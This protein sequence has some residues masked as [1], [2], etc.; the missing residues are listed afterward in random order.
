MSKQKADKAAPA[1][2]DE[3]ERRQRFFKNYAKAAKPLGVK[4]C[5]VLLDQLQQSKEDGGDPSQIVLVDQP[6]GPNGTRALCAAVCGLGLSS[7]SPSPYSDLRT[8]V[9][10]NCE[11]GS[12]GAWSVAE[13]LRVS[14]VDGPHCVPLER[15]EISQNA[16]G[17]AGCRYIGEALVT[18]CNA[19]LHN[20][21]LDQDVSIGDAGVEALVKGLGSNSVLKVLSLA[22]CGVGLA[23]ATSLTKLL[24]SPFSKLEVLNLNGNPLGS[25]GLYVLADVLVWRISDGSAAPRGHAEANGNRTL[26]SL[27]LSDCG[28][29]EGNALDDEGV[30]GD[31]GDGGGEGAA[32]GGG[33]AAPASVAIAA[34]GLPSQSLTEDA[35]RAF[36]DMIASNPILTHVDFNFNLINDRQASHLA[37]AF[38]GNRTLEEFN[39][40]IGIPRPLF[41]KMSRVSPRAGGK[42]GKKGKRGKGGK[43][44]RKEDASR[45]ASVAH[46]SLAGPASTV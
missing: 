39:L 7:M 25:A 1:N 24:S 2:A 10:R 21:V 22:I 38:T 16:I 3:E 29:G 31:G 26:Q 42:K 9:L 19:Y 18:G 20:L 32:V 43:S 33:A 34:G 37:T 11:C 46:A 40:S 17:L 36:R 13:M 5:R 12:M 35:V 14:G 15:L 45:D 6:L 28:I 4:P 44:P 27:C 41:D 23:G 8:L 30:D